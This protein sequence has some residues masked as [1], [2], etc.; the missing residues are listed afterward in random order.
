MAAGLG[1]IDF[2]KEHRDRV[3]SVI[4]MLGEPGTVD[5]LGIG[6]VRDAL[7]DWL[8]PGVSTIQTRPK[9]FL[10][11]PQLIQDYVT[12]YKNKQDVPAL[13]IWLREKE[14]ALMHELAENYNYEVNNGVIGVSVAANDGELARRASSIYWNGIR[15]HNIIDTHYSLNDYL[16]Y[17]TL[18][19]MIRNN[20]TGTET[21]DPDMFSELDG[22]GLNLHKFPETDEPLKLDLSRDEAS[23]LRDQFRADEAGR[24]R[25]ENILRH[26][27]IYEEDASFARE[28]P[29][30]EVFGN[31]LLE[32]GRL[33]DASSHLL[34]IALDFAF[35]IHAAHIRF[36]VL[37]HRQ[38]GVEGF[39]DRWMEWL[40]SFN[41]QKSVLQRFDINYLLQKIAP[42]TKKFT[43]NF[44]RK[45]YEELMQPVINEAKIDE[46]VRNQEI[47]NKNEK[48]KLASRS[49]EYYDWV[50][51]RE[52]PYRFY[53]VRTIMN[54][55]YS[56]FNA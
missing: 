6:V 29:N 31:L 12:A 33:S 5:E 45:F 9:Y 41:T 23:Y 7:A 19:G 32:G 51:I 28:S 36:N 21:D 54:D 20:A 40:S 4:D 43:Q 42:R 3:F 37:L 38:A 44:L 24:K 10:L 49:G 52:I 30:F 16:H 26:L 2:S 14:H 47:N 55:L 39:D 8:F 50:G 25:P 35:L 17:N 22:F 11:L 13:S 34:Q 53:Q 48:S 27:M 18:A 1:W 46:L 15:I 56:A